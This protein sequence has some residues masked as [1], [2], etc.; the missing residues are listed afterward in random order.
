MFTT[1]YD[2]GLFYDSYVETLCSYIEIE[3]CQALPNEGLLELT[4]VSLALLGDATIVDV[5][6]LRVKL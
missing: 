6:G 2:T 1:R 5:C 3:G 4:L